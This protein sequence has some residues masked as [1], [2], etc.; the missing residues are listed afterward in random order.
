MTSDPGSSGNSATD[1]R[2]AGA[3]RSAAVR[4]RGRPPLALAAEEAASRWPLGRIIGAAMLALGLV[5]VASIIV[6]TL[7]LSNLNRDRNRVVDTLDPAAFHGS[8]L[9]AAC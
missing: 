4:R 1:S 3:P 9:Y 8:Q 6:A 7:A 2:Q 5:L